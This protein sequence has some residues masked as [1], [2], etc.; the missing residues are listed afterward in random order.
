MGTVHIKL[1]EDYC[2]EVEFVSPGITGLAQPMDVSVMRSFKSRCRR[3]D[4]NYHINHDFP[5]TT[6]ARR[7]L[8]TQIVLL[9]WESIEEKR[10]VRGFVK[11]G[12]VPIG[13]RVTDGTFRV[14]GPKS[15]TVS[16]RGMMQRRGGGSQT[17]APGRKRLKGPDR[18]EAARHRA[19]AK[20]GE[21]VMNKIRSDWDTWDTSYGDNEWQQ[22]EGVVR[23]LPQQLSD[24]E[25]RSILPIG[26]S[27]VT[28][29]RNC[30]K[31]GIDHFHTRRVVSKPCH[32]FDDVVLEAFKGHC[33]T[34]KLE[35]GF[36]CPH[37][38]PRQYFTEQNLTWRTQPDLT[39]AE[40]GGIILRKSTHIED[41]IA[42]RR[43]VSKF[44]KEFSALHAPEQNLPETI[45]PDTFDDDDDASNDDKV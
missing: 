18:Q 31:S 26:G 25:I 39:E 6:T 8:M 28:R 2:S 7:F 24:R 10:I 34:W 21:D 5:A 4:I 14:P 11:A 37:R 44:V 13:P 33:A 27:R 41:A 3:L 38:R 17:T 30:L 43:F 23:S 42:Q 15:E 36:P 29:L 12:L 16:V 22:S 9:A 19:I 40:K 35:D 32:A 45:N 20:L 1:E